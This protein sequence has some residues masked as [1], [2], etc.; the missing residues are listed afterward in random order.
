MKK[1]ITVVG[2]RPQ[3]I[4][5]AA[6]SRAIEND[7]FLKEIKIHTQQHSSE[8]MSGQ[9]F[10]DLK[11]NLPDVLLEAPS[12]NSIEQI[13][14]MSMSL[15]KAFQ[16]HSPDMVVL[17][18]DTNSTLAGA[19]AAAHMQIP[20][21][22]V[23]AGLRSFNRAM[24]EEINRVT[25]DHLSTLLFT[26]TAGAT[27]QLQKEGVHNTSEQSASAANPAVI[28]C[29]DVMLDN[30]LYYSNGIAKK[31]ENYI[32]LTLHRPSNV[33]NPEFLLPFLQ[34][35]LQI[36]IELGMELHFAIHP[37]TT[38]SLEKSALKDEWERLK[39]NE[40]FILFPPFNYSETLGKLTQASLV[41]TDS[42]GLCKEAFYMGTPCLILRSETEW[43]ELVDNGFAKV[44]HNDLDKIKIESQSYLKNG[45]P[46]SI[47]LYGNGHSAEI[48]LASIKSYFA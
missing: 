41:W 15:Q 17:Y 32:F 1:I 30:A 48:I 40:K 43:T 23:E 45:M 28:E 9:L 39:L 12:G 10:S 34:E 46:E 42:G 31:R 26:P 7:E 38:I 22:H 44:V 8:S 13:A 35:L 18:G 2:A 4:K 11:I 27:E 36:S 20:I 33:D 19:I 29:G 47:D 24:P 16:Q 37:R 3:I 21:A 25:T 14:H 6:L 5:S